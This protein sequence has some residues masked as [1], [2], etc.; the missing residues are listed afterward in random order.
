MY[1]FPEHLFARGFQSR[2]HQIK[3]VD[4]SMTSMAAEEENGDDLNVVGTLFAQNG[5]DN[6]YD[7]EDFVQEIAVDSATRFRISVAEDDGSMPG[8]LFAC[9]VWNGAVRMACRSSQTLMLPRA[10]R[11]CPLSLM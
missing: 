2:R 6:S 5:E 8:A 1:V 3:R 11:S 4:Y 7:P 10:D 9:A